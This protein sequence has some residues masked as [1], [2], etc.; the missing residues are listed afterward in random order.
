LVNPQ[1]PRQATPV[2]DPER[3]AV[4]WI[5]AA[6]AA[7]ATWGDESEPTVEHIDSGVTPRRRAVGSVRRG[8]AR[9]AGG[10]YVAGHGTEEKHERELR[11][12]F[13]EVAARLSDL[14]TIEV[15]GRGYPHEWFAELLRRVAARRN[16][17]TGVD[18]RTVA[19]RP[20]D[21]QLMAQLRKL[22]GTE[23]PRRRVGRYR[24]P[25]AESAT[26]TGRP[27]KPSAGRRT[28]RPERLPET[29]H[30]AEEIELMLADAPPEA[31]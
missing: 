1:G 30:I 14:D 9:P 13:T 24:L 5:D 4:V 17:A 6:G 2:I 28:L 10:G 8:P 20:S 18:V 19:R 31:E 11:A 26:A 21:R 7:I 3:F 25:T 22:S 27:L 12:F 16:E 15:V 29:K 23:L